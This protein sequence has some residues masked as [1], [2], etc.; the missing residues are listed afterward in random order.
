MAQFTS[1]SYQ[2]DFFRDMTLEY[3]ETLNEYQFETDPY[4]NSIL[5]E[6]LANQKEKYEG[7]ISSLKESKSR[8]Y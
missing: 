7:I 6:A 8:K 4:L 5:F 1:L 2:R 3:V